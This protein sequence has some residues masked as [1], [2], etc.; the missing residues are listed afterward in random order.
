MAGRDSLPPQERQ[1]A[2]LDPTDDLVFEERPAIDLKIQEAL[3]RA[4]SAYTDD[5]I[6]APIPDK[7][8]LLLARLE[9]KEQ[10]GK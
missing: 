4:L 9:A 7:F 5:I 2:A 10:D 8:L 3:G 1:N 6:R